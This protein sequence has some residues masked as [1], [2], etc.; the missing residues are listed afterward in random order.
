RSL[1][2]R[3]KGEGVVLP[4]TMTNDHFKAFCRYRLMWLDV[5][6]EPGELRAV[7]YKAG[8]AIGEKALR[9]AG[10]VAE[11]RL[12]AEPLAG[13]DENELIWV[14]AEAYDAAGVRVPNATD[15]VAFS[16]EGPG[17]ILGVGN[18]DAC[19]CVSF[20]DFSGHRLFGGRATAVVRREGV[21]E[22]NVRASLGSIGRSFGCKMP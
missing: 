1:G 6:Y 4:P 15:K 2:R 7:A 8:R 9:T 3:R 5:P 14:H 16:L 10:D 17:R 21:G 20:S 18:G 11:L 13:K 22:M 19:E 12:S